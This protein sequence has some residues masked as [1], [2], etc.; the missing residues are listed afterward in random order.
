MNNLTL[1][2]TVNEQGCNSPELRCYMDTTYIR[3]KKVE[4]ATINFS[5]VSVIGNA[6]RLNS[7]KL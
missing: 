5:S 3:F 4:E 2:Y 6:L 1:Q 7:T